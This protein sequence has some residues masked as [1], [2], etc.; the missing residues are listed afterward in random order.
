MRLEQ[1]ESQRLQ[2]LAGDLITQP[3]AKPLDRWLYLIKYLKFSINKRKRVNICI[4][5]CKVLV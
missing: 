4:L 3:G 5:P 2:A 1:R